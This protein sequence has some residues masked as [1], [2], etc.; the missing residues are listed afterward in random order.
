MPTPVSESVI[1]SAFVTPTPARPDVGLRR[2]PLSCAEL[3]A[4]LDSTEAQRPELVLGRGLVDRALE[5]LEHGGQATEIGVARPE[6][7]QLVASRGHTIDST[8]RRRAG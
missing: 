6:I 5:E 7:V 1:S 3:V 2:A 4:Q 8:G